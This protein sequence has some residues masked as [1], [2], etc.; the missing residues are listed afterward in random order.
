[1]E[2]VLPLPAR[3][4]GLFASSGGPCVK[5][6]DVKRGV[7][8]HTLSNHVKTVTS[9]CLDGSETRLVSGSLDG[10]VKVY[11]L[12]GFKVVFSFKYPAGVMSLAAAG[13]KKFVVGMVSGLLSIRQRSVKIDVSSIV[14][15]P[16]K[17]RG[18]SW[19]HFARGKSYR[20]EQ[21]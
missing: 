9:L 2:S 18:G 20:P 7:M 13:E 15:G 21:V 14:A 17:I 4:A 1:M 19:K 16:E 10:H 12:D 6:W 3:M 5:I 8:V 11:G